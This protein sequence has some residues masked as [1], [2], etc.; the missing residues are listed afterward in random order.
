MRSNG[1]TDTR[2]EGRKEVRRE[3]REE[4]RKNTLY[5][6]FATFERP[7][8]TEFFPNQNMKNASN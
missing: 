4:E 1:R 7:Y 8:D 6:S 3:G 2:K 5:L